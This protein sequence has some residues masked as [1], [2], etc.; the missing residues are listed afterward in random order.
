MYT[1]R[2][3]VSF[4]TI[5]LISPISSPASLEDMRSGSRMGG[6]GTPSEAS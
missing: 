1:R 3:R 4:A 2:G 6:V 5:R